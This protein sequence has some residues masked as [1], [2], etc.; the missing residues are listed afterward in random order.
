MATLKSIK[1]KYLEAS[2]GAT[3]GVTTNTE[4]VS[5]LS[6][7]LATADTLAKFNMV[8]GATDDY[9]DATGVS[10]PVS[11]LAVR[12]PANYYSGDNPVTNRTSITSTPGPGVYSVGGSAID[13][14]VVA[15]GGP[16]G[17]Q[18]GGG[19]GAGGLIYRPALPVT[20]GGTAPVTIGAGGPNNYTGG[21]TPGSSTSY[22]AGGD[23]TFGPGPGNST[24]LTA[25]GGGHG[26]GWPQQG[27]ST[28][29]SG[30]GGGGPSAGGGGASQPSQPG[31]SGTYGFGNSGASA[32]SH[33]GGAGGAG[34]AGSGTSGGDGRAYTIADGSSSVYYAGG[35]GAGATGG[36]SGH[37]TGGQGGGGPGDPSPNYTGVANTGGGGGGGR[38][39]HYGSGFGG[40]GIIIISDESPATANMTL[41]STA[42]TAQSQ[43]DDVRIVLDEY[44]ATGSATI[45]TDLKAYASRDNG[46]TFTQIT[47]TDS[48]TIESN[49]KLLIGSA[50]I[51]GQPAGTSM[52]YKLTTHN[53]KDIRIYGTSLTWA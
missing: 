36:G 17:R 33:G 7:K 26:G 14:L 50:D 13:V 38:A 10:A 48:G 42:Y 8:D 5:L 29:G 46:T 11:P 30:G 22:T 27:G 15:G 28:G 44:T 52:V 24:A 9:N 45:N 37:G 23:T 19:G 49:H 41:Q 16:G 18:H 40:S 21:Q 53:T 32:S 47:L 1:N 20:P 6:L 35:G 25:K 2:D 51:S 34:A 4:N 3:L 39:N 31:D 43:P 12:N